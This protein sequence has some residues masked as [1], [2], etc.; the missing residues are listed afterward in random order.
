MARKRRLT[1]KRQ[2]T[3]AEWEVMDGV[4]HLDRKVTV[5]D[6]VNQSVSQW[7]ESLYDGADDYE[8]SV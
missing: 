3:E 8:Y 4:W 5:R 1:A 2:L 6:I 7:R